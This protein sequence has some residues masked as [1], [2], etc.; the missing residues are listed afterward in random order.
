MQETPQASSNAVPRPLSR[1]I[2]VLGCASCVYGGACAA[3]E[4]SA[5]GQRSAR[6]FL[7]RS[8]CRSAWGEGRD[9]LARWTQG[10]PSVV[11]AGRYRR[12]VG[13]FEAAVSVLLGATSSVAVPGH[14]Y[15]ASNL[16]LSSLYIG[17]VRR[18]AY[19]MAG[20]LAFGPSFVKLIISNIVRFTRGGATRR[21]R[22]RHTRIHA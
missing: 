13:S 18:M 8:F 19:T 22:V 1:R 11:R 6:G 16:A 15:S 9:A 5:Q 20:A 3:L 4:H 10:G 7:Y 17:Y 21:V 2:V 12:A 14:R